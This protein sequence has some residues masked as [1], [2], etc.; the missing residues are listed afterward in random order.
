MPG[1]KGSQKALLNKLKRQ[2]AAKTAKQTE[3]A[4]IAKN[5]V[6]NMSEK[7]YH[8]YTNLLTLST[9]WG[10]ANLTLVPQSDDDTTRNG[11]ELIQSSLRINYNMIGADGT[12]MCRFV[13]I[14]WLA[15][16]NP[17]AAQ[18]FSNDASGY[19]PLSMY[20]HDNRKLFHVFY[21]SGVISQ[22]LS[23][24]SVQKTGTVSLGLK[25][26]RQRFLGGATTNVKGAVYIW[27]CSDSSAASHPAMTIRSRL[28]YR[29]P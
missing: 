29:D 28:S 14:R 17:T 12:N 11:D 6:M 15:D 8:D 25:K 7:K 2:K 20:N 3:I 16:G 21:D 24:D 19:A 10:N 22:V 13:I 18:L 26:Y 23:N 5:V 4:K 27:Y 9:T 1:V